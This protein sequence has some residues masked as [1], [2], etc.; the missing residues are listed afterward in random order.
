MKKN[1]S[2]KPEIAGFSEGLENMKNDF[3]GWLKANWKWVFGIG[4]GVGI[5]AYLLRRKNVGKRK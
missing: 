2:D 3:L 1:P 4:A 5:T